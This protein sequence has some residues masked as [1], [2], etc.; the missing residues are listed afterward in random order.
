MIP[1]EVHQVDHV[2]MPERRSS[3]TAFDALVGTGA[4][5][6]ALV[7]G[8]VTFKIFAQSLGPRE[9]G[10]IGVTFGVTGLAGAISAVPVYLT[11]VTLG[12]ASRT[13][14]GSVRTIGTLVIAGATVF[15]TILA[16]ISID[17]SKFPFVVTIIVSEVIVGG[18]VSCELGFVNSLVG[19]RQVA[20]LR[21]AQVA[22]R[23]I[24]LVVLIVID[25]VSLG[26]YAL[27]QT[28]A[29]VGLLAVVVL[30]RRHKRLPTIRHAR[31]QRAHAATAARFAAGLGVLSVQN[32]YDKAV[33][34][35]F[36]FATELGVYT[37]AYRIVN[38]FGVPIE[39]LIGA[40]YSRQVALAGSDLQ[41]L[42]RFTNRVMLGGLA[43]TGAVLGGFA[44]LGHWLLKPLGDQYAGTY[45]MVVALLGV[46]ALRCIGGVICDML[47]ASGFQP[48]VLK[49]MAVSGVLTVASY[50]ITIPMWGW[51]GAVFGTFLGEFVTATLVYTASRRR[52]K[53]ISDTD[54]AVAHG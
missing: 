9:Y 11:T 45:L 3:S 43:Y 32:D 18:L 7:V 39:Q 20:Q 35:Q 50:Y 6:L 25:R 10:I 41:Q 47:N 52:L 44:L 15:A 4:T 17:S 28:T 2:G 12:Q 40:S 34:S 46:L 36:G 33:L 22:V 8:L 53:S 24:V 19:Y 51:K 30:Y 13:Q 23:C 49:S 37:A 54:R 16:A 5:G 27:M 29:N 21:L 26:S 1:D 31:P 42:H 48:L 38:I 14:S